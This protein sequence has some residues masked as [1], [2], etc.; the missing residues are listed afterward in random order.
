M[1]R[2]KKKPEPWIKIDNKDLGRTVKVKIRSE[3][4]V[5]MLLSNQIVLIGPVSWCVREK[6]KSW[7]KVEEIETQPTN[8]RVNRIVTGL[9]KL[10]ENLEHEKKKE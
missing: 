4:K 3:R 1:G 10:I 6:I 5:L 7:P 9:S 2:K 8:V